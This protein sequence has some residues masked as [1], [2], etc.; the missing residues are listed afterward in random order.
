M[1]EEF[2][3]RN[4]FF[5]Q[6]MN[7]VRSN[8]QNQNYKKRFGKQES[9]KTNKHLLKYDLNEADLFFVRQTDDGNLTIVLN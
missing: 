6:Q 2:M 5:P 4:K 7:R 8:L 3:K 1:E 9:N